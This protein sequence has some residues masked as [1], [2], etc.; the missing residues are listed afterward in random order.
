MEEL[1]YGDG[2]FDAAIACNSVQYGDELARAHLGR[3][4]RA[5]GDCS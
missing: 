5:Q 1:P 4:R 2:A 3:A